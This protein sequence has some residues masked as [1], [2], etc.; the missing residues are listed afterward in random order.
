M[1]MYAHGWKKDG[2]VYAVQV[3]EIKHGEKKEVK[4]LFK[5]WK[6]SCYGWNVKSGN[7][8]I[9]F[10]K[11]FE[12]QK[13]WL[14][15]AKKCPIKLSELKVKSGKEELI[16]LSCKEKKKRVKNELCDKKEEQESITQKGKSKTRSGPSR[17]KSS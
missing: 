10:S 8:I 1:K 17:R 14:M 16:Q 13:E 12:D 9:V 5:D 11:E 4:N 3:N 15:W 6:E 7:I 2:N